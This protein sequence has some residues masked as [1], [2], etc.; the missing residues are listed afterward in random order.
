M[1]DDP[2]DAWDDEGPHIELIMWVL[3]SAVVTGVAG[4]IVLAVYLLN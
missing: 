4:V 3:G 2:V 1:D